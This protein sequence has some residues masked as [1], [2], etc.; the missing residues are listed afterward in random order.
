VKTIVDERTP[1]QILDVIA[2]KG[3]EILDALS[4]L[5]SHH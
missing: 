5:R 2:F 4:I 3:Q 1:E